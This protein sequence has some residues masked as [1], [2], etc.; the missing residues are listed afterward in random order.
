MAFVSGNAFVGRAFA[1][2]PQTC[3]RAGA[4][5]A[6]KMALEKDDKII[7]TLDD[8]K[9]DEKRNGW[10]FYSE[11]WNGR[12]AMLGLIIAIGTEQINPAHPT[13]VH[14]LGALIGQ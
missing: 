1:G 9:R 14:Q 5:V 7:V 2:R 10:T 8:L 11:A 3:K 12:L 4:P 13:I 6:V